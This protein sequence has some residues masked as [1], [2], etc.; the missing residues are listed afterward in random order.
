MGDN[1]NP[2]ERQILS[3]YLKMTL[4]NKPRQQLKSSRKANPKCSTKVINNYF[5]LRIKTPMRINYLYVWL[6]GAR[7]YYLVRLMRVFSPC[8][9]HWA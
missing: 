2:V 1:G 3:V 5:N 8:L 4:Q 6:I 7:I 9:I